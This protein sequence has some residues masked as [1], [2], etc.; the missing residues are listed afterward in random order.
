MIKSTIIGALVSLPFVA[1]A[2]MG[3]V[4]AGAVN[5]WELGKD[6]SFAG[7]VWFLI[8]YTLPKLQRE[9]TA[10]RDKL[11][12]M[13]NKNQSDNRETLERLAEQHK[14][15]TLSGHQAASDLSKEIAG[16]KFRSKE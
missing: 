13:I 4:A 16:L 12:Q 14:Q 3:Q 7:L 11:F 6:I 15:A 5:P 8:A 10:E 1:K 9:H 2:V